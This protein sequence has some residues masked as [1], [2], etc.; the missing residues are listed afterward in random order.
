MSDIK[1]FD[2]FVNEGLFSSKNDKEVKDIFK[3]IKDTFDIEKLSLAGDSYIYDEIIAVK[4][5]DMMIPSYELFIDD[6]KIKCSFLL[7]REIFNFFDEKYKESKEE[8]I[9]YK[10]D[11]LKKAKD[12]YKSIDTEL[13]QNAKDK[14]DSTKKDN[15]FHG[16]YGSY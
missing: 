4:I 5:I 6:S 10:K 13:F 2:E 1:K 12:K 3:V 8:H 9:E 14:Y 7:K 15:P 16:H 11:I